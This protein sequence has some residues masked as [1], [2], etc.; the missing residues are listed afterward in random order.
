MVIDMIHKDR[1]QEGDPWH[2]HQGFSV[3][4]QAPQG[5]EPGVIHAFQR[6]P[7]ARR[8]LRKSFQNFLPA[9]GLRMR[10]VRSFKTVR[11]HCRRDLT[12]AGRNVK[13]QL[14]QRE[15]FRVRFPC[16]LVV[17]NAFEHPLS[18]LCFLVELHQ[19]GF[20][21]AHDHSFPCTS[22]LVFTSLRLGESN[23]PLSSALFFGCNFFA[24]SAVNPPVD[25]IPVIINAALAMHAGHIHFPSRSCP[26]YCGRRLASAC[27]RTPSFMYVQ[28]FTAPSRWS[29]AISPNAR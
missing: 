24:A 6:G 11:H 19:K 29:S 4:R 10:E 28:P 16:E 23:E 15:R 3:S 21:E 1:A 25:M 2:L 26:A 27:L 8:A 5:D 12:R 18:R 13:S 7:R 14:S 17:R 20:C 22:D 9:P